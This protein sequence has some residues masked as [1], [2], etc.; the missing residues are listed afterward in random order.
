MKTKISLALIIFSTLFVGC[1]NE[2]SVDSLEVVKTEVVDKNFQV[3]LDVVVKKNDDFALY[4]TQDGTSDFKDAPIWIGVKGSEASQK[5]VFSLPEDVIPTHLRI[6]FGMNKDQEPIALNNYKMTYA[7]KSFEAPGAMF[8][9][10]FRP[11]LECTNVD[12]E[13]GLIIPV[14]KGDKYFGPSFYPEQ[15]ICD[16]IDKLVK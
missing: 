8:F 7:G 15:L 2:K 6:D 5:V 9:K 16:E 3:T 14:K 12:P 11:N 13:K 4:Y 1:K 10:Y